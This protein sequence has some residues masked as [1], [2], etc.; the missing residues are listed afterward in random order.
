MFAVS[1]Y[2]LDLECLVN[3]CGHAAATSSEHGECVS[4][5]VVSDGAQH[6]VVLPEF[7]LLPALVDLAVAEVP[8]METFAPA[9]TSSQLRPP[10]ELLLTTSA[11]SRRGPPA[12][13]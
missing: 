4:P 5:V 7:S 3:E 11:L 9:H 1:G 6:P 12:L 13:A 8:P 2:F 10:P